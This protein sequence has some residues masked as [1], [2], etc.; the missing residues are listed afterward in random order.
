MQFPATLVQLAEPQPH[1]AAKQEKIL[2]LDLS[3][4]YNFQQLWFSWQ[5]R[6]PP[7]ICLFVKDPACITYIEYPWSP[8]Y[9]S[10]LRFLL[11]KYLLYVT[12]FVNF[13]KYSHIQ[14]HKTQDNGAGG[15][16]IDSLTTIHTNISA[17]TVTVLAIAL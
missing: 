15:R 2:R 8:Y 16:P 13:S 17:I 11:S 1:P 9:K 7:P 12:N 4:S 14:K 10:I 6:P 3:I 5:K